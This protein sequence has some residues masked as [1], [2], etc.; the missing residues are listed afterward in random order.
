MVMRFS[1]PGIKYFKTCCAIASVIGVPIT[2]EYA[3]SFTSAPSS[4]R[5]LDF[6]FVA[7]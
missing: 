7:M 4:S 2:E 6:V 1:W 3:T 5:T